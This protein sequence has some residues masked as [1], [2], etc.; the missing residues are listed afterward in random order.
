MSQFEKDI[1]E[2]QMKG[3]TIANQLARS[4]IRD[5]TYLAEGGVMDVTNGS[6]GLSKNTVSNFQSLLEEIA[7][8]AALFAA[9][10]IYKE[11]ANE[12]LN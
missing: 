11:A 4:I 3:N 1:K 8:S 7:V 2:V 10:T 9:V 5:L 12:K 6:G